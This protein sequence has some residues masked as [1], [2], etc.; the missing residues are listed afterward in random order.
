MTIEEV[1]THQFTVNVHNVAAIPP[2]A[3]FLSMRGIDLKSK[4]QSMHE[5]LEGILEAN[6]GEK[7]AHDKHATN[8]PRCFASGQQFRYPHD[9]RGHEP[10]CPQKDRQERNINPRLHIRRK[11]EDIHHKHGCKISAEDSD[12]RA[13]GNSGKRDQGH[14][15]AFLKM[16]FVHWIVRLELSD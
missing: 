8:N 1:S 5:W 15:A 14:R 7:K 9:A 3:K 12:Q 10:G 11:L 13:E 4:R 6:T 16:N 2:A